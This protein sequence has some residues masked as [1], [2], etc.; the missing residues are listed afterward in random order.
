MKP[1]LHVPALLSAALLGL[2]LANTMVPFRG[3]AGRQGVYRFEVRA[4][5]TVSGTAQLF[6][7]AGRGFSEADASRVPLAAGAP[8]VLSFP[9]HAQSVRGLRFDPIN[10]D[11]QVTLRE[12]VIRRPDGSVLRTIPLDAFTP[13]NQIE[14][15]VRRGDALVVQPPPGANDPFLFVSV[16]DGTLH[17]TVS[18]LRMLLPFLERGLPWSA[19]LVALVL[20]WRFAGTGWQP[21]VRAGLAWLRDRAVQRPQAAVVAAAGLAMIISSYPVIFCGASFV[22]PNYG[23]ALLYDGYPTLPGGGSKE[24]VDV[25]GADIG[26]IMWQQVP[27]SSVQSR[28]LFHDF[29]LPL[30]NRYNS[31]G[32]VLLGQGQTMFGDPLHTGVLLA[33]GAA[34][35]WDLKYLAAKWLLGVALG[36]TVLYT[37]RH[38][39]AALT[40]GFASI[41]VGF[42]VFRVNHPAFFSFCYGPWVLYAW[43]RVTGARS[44]RGLFLALLGLIAANGMLLTSGTAKEA[45]V[46]LFTMNFAGVMMLLCDASPWSNRLRRLGGAV[47]AGGVFMLLTAPVWLTFLDAIRASYSSYNAAFAFQLQPSLALGFFDEV[48]LR[49]FWENEQVFNPSSN[50]LILLGVLACLVNLRAIAAN[51]YALGAGLGALLPVVFV[52]GLVPPR[53][54]ANLPFLG[55]IHHID[56]SFGVGLIHLFAVLAGF[57]FARIATRLGEKEGRGDIAIAALLLGGLV[58]HYIGLTQAV[59]RST[60]TALLWGQ[61]VP[62]SF[63]V[64]G[65]LG[66][67][68]LGAL[69]LTFAARHLL[70]H[71][72]W[73][74]GATLLAASCV[75]LLLW[76]HG[77]HQRTQFPDHTLNAA[78]RAQFDAPSAALAA[79]RKD[80]T[81]PARVTGFA[82]HFFHGWN[83]VYALEGVS[84][85]DALMNAHMRALQEAF[86]VERI[87]DWRLFILP[88]TL[89]QARAFYDLLNVRYYLAGPGDA[90]PAGAGL[91]LLARADLAVWRSETAW[92]RAFFTDRVVTYAT[93]ADFAALVRRGDHRP[94]AA[95][96]AGERDIPVSPAGSLATRKVTPARDYRLTTNTTAFTVDAASAGVI[97]LTEAWLD[98]DFT[99][100]INGRPA[101]LFRVNHA[102][103]GI[104]VSQ[105]GSYQ[106][107]IRYRP[108]RFNLAL[109]MC[110]AGL[111]IVGGT[112]WWVWRLPR[113]PSGTG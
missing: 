88:E 14:S 79:V 11:A 95:V 26:A 41:F 3:Q 44:P 45:Y 107:E 20:V 100:T 21:R 34:W 56:N 55:N 106:V 93:P 113:N 66:A 28:A 82:G 23:A 64:W 72:R 76:R 19:A 9:I 5:T 105:G 70:R 97:V 53:W 17:L 29:E 98:G 68:L 84:G 104:H 83:N 63:F 109:G 49:P 24:V 35:A 99:A 94:L 71:R 22:S 81:E 2:V 38:L 42:F 86:G 47:A 18:W 112:G 91:T 102:F 90:P 51:G 37:T 80:M 48:L 12:A 92:P 87:W 61:T 67:L 85:P 16:G 13:A 103:K 43:C 4:T 75:I 7:D 110:L 73:T 108:R 60:Y 89:P 101:A 27:L 1:L 36:L 50:F 69:G 74:A 57:G 8:V 30:W 77:L 10:H 59:Q 65:S 78:P 96:Q 58:L 39:G 40:I 31:G 52:F 54:I 111:A 6:Y 62:R 33:G 25:R 32:T 15:L 46:S